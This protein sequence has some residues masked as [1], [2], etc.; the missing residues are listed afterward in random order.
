MRWPAPGPSW[1]R[2]DL[3]SLSYAAC[4]LAVLNSRREQRVQL[5]NGR[6]DREEVSAADR[7][8]LVSK[9]DRLLGCCGLS[10]GETSELRSQDRPLLVN[11]QSRLHPA[12]MSSRAEQARLAL[13]RQDVV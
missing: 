4:A 10:P 5:S 3:G 2:R 13:N 7:G 11:A 1:S 6:E 12:S 8:A 9:H